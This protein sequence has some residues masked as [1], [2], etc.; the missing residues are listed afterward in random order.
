MTQDQI[1]RTCADD[2]RHLGA[3]LEEVLAARR[4][5][6][7]PHVTSEVMAGGFYDELERLQGTN[8]TYYAGEIM[9]FSTVELCAQYS[10]DLVARFFEGDRVGAGGSA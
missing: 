10:R 1:E 4:W 2:L 3:R 6:Y 5:R 8:R 9:S 7:F